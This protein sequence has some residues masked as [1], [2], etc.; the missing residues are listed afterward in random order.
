MPTF[1]DLN[2]RGGL[3]DLMSGDDY[4]KMDNSHMEFGDVVN[5]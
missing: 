4:I 2:D 3:V 1:L 5:G